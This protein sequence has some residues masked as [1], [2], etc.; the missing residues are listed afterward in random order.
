MQTF[1]RDLEKSQIVSPSSLT[2]PGQVPQ[3]SPHSFSK[4]RMPSSPG[5]APQ[6][7]GHQQHWWK[8]EPLLLCCFEAL[9]SWRFFSLI[10]RTS[11]HCRVSSEQRNL[12][13]A[14]WSFGV[15]GSGSQ[16]P[17][18]WALGVVFWGFGARN[19]WGLWPS[20]VSA[21]C[22]VSFLA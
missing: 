22:G 7:E 20:A 3:K 9:K 4:P 8:I 6:R 19:I 16:S 10:A 13:T 14:S 2:P 11:P 18:I 5:Q 21:S 1:T 17:G 12:H 15:L